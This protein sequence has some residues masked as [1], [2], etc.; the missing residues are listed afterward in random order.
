M[1]CEKTCNEF[2]LLTVR[3]DIS[4][5]LNNN[6]NG[7]DEDNDTDD[8]KDDDGDDFSDCCDDDDCS[9]RRPTQTIH[10]SPLRT[11][12]KYQHRVGS[13]RLSNDL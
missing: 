11:G 8:S 5:W 2:D 3:T 1:Q 7:D 4:W 13:K 9:C 6:G 12:Q 10:S